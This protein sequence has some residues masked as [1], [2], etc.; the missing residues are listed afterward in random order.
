MLDIFEFG[1]PPFNRL[2]DE[3]GGATVHFV[4]LHADR[5]ERLVRNRSAFRLEQKRSREYLRLDNTNLGAPDAA[6]A[7]MKRYGFAKV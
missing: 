4:E 5:A 1:S 2:V 6:E 3:D 7:I